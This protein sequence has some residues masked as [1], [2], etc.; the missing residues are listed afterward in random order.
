MGHEQPIQSDGFG[1]LRPC[2][3]YGKIPGYATFKLAATEKINKSFEVYGGVTNLMNKRYANFDLLANNNLNA[4]APENFWAV[5]QPRAF[6]FGLRA[7][8]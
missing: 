8:F 5:G 6:Y 4:G 2:A 3:T 1:P 7:F